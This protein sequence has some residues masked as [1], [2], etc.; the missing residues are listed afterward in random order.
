[1]QTEAQLRFLLRGYPNTALVMI[2]SFL[3]PVPRLAAATHAHANA[4]AL[5]GVPYV[6]PRAY[7]AEA[8][9][10]GSQITAKMTREYPPASKLTSSTFATTLTQGILHPNALVHKSL[11]LGL[12]NWWEMMSELAVHCEQNELAA[13]MRP[14]PEKPVA[15][16][17]NKFHVCEKALSTYS[18]AEAVTG[19]MGNSLLLPKD[20]ETGQ[21]VGKAFSGHEASWK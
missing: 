17:A 20:L 9:A 2:G 7:G 10:V 15:A 18:A 8:P 5:Y 13:S 4:S 1:M 19:K 21:E 11:A 14:F 12:L 3:E 16:L 6:Q